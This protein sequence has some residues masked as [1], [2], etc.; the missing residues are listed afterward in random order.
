MKAVGESCE[1]PLTYYN[2]ISRTIILLQTMA[3]FRVKKLIFSSSSTVYG[4]DPHPPCKEP[5]ASGASN[6][7]GSTKFFIEQILFDLQ[8]SDPE[9]SIVCLRYFNPI[10]A[11]P[12]SLIGED[13]INVPKNF[14]PYLSLVAT[15]HLESFSIFGDDYDTPD[16]TCIRDYIHVVDVARAHISAVDYTATHKSF[17]AMNLGCGKGFSVLE[18]IHA[19][20]K[21][22]NVKIPYKVVG[23]RAGDI[24][25]IGEYYCD[26]SKAKKLLNWTRIDGLRALRAIATPAARPPPPT[27]TTTVS[28]SGSWL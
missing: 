23:R 13:P 2:K 5:E 1:I 12:S 4:K 28:T 6:P 10:G 16:G 27:G 17:E 20:E 11:H 24:T 26:P 8:K 21:A 14:L 19:Y 3:K 22:C 15:G 25:Y 7:Y 9:W 18:V